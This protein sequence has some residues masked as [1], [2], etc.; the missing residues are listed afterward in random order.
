MLIW[1]SGLL[2][3]IA[4]P[5]HSFHIF[6]GLILKLSVVFLKLSWAAM[7]AMADEAYASELYAIEV[8]ILDLNCELDQ[9]LSQLFKNGC[10]VGVNFF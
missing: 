6:P 2:Q 4:F 1:T 9:R 5:K 8:K 3:R 7:A 10:D